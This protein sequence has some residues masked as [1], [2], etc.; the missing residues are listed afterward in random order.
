MIVVTLHFEND[1]RFHLSITSNY[2]SSSYPP[3]TLQ[4]ILSLSGISVTL[5]LI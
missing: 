4:G 5:A 2:L 1:H 3:E